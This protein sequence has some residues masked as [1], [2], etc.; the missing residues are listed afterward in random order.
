V[1]GEFQADAEEEEEEEEDR[2]ELGSVAALDEVALQHPPY[3]QHSGSLAVSSSSALLPTASALRPVLTASA[4]SPLRRRSPTASDTL[5]SSASFWNSMSDTQL[6]KHLAPTSSSASSASSTS[7]ATSNSSAAASSNPSPHNAQAAAYHQIID[8]FDPTATLKAGGGG[9]RSVRSSH[10]HRYSALMQ[11]LDSKS[12]F[13]FPDGKVL[14]K[15]AFLA[16]PK[17]SEVVVAPAAPAPAATS[18]AAAAAASE[19]EVNEVPEEVDKLHDGASVPASLSASTASLST[20]ASVDDRDPG[21]SRSTVRSSKSRRRAAAP[22]SSS[23]GA[24]PANAAAVAGDAGAS[25]SFAVSGSHTLE[26]AL[27]ELEIAHQEFQQQLK[28]K[29]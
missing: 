20:A 5:H 15:P 28:S 23:S 24:G 11:S 4:H 21:A 2:P 12:A 9:E 27:H 18:A 1:V 22:S 13:V 19:S 25:I 16:L 8:P 3:T 14:P 10:N 17:P 6:S 29:P 7:T 26:D